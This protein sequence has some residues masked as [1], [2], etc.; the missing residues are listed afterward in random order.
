M[1]DT[2]IRRTIDAYN[3]S[4]RKYA[5]KFDNYPT[6]QNKMAD[7]CRQY[8]PGGARIL[9]LGCGPGNNIK[10]MLENDDTCRSTGVD[11]SAEFI[12]IA[13][14]R[15]PQLDFRQQDIRQLSGPAQYEA[16]IASF[17]IVHLANAEVPDFF[18]T[19]SGLLA[20]GGCLYLSYMNGNGCRFE[21]TSFSRQEI[22]FNFYDDAYI[23]AQLACNNLDILEINKAEYPEPDGSFT[24]D[25]F[26]YARKK[27]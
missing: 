23:T 20:T 1:Q 26:V 7:F 11:L 14:E 12:T 22:F 18:Q 5:E 13:R 17:C 19:V 15:F 16:V 25:T 24:T 3:N 4:A 2:R 8:I 21:T 9:D 27:R 10:T 6:Y